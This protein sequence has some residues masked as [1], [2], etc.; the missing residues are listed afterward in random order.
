MDDKIY[1][2]CLAIQAIF[3]AIQP[4]QV[5]QIVSLL[6]TIASAVVGLVFKILSWYNESKKDGKIDSKELEEGTKMT[7]EEL[8]KISK[9]INDI[10]K[11]D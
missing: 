3:T 1:G 6:I 11:K 9:E 5:L 2:G 4:S 7:I 10:N 8:D